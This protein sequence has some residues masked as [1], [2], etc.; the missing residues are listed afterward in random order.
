MGLVVYE[1]LRFDGKSSLDYDVRISGSGTYAAPARDVQSVS[2]PGRNG[3]L[4]IDNGRFSNVKIKYPAYITKN[5]RENFDAFK[6][7]MLSRIGYK[8]LEDSYHPEYYRMAC[9]SQAVE[10]KMST[11]NRAGSFDLVFDCDPRRFLKSGTR[12]KVYSGAGIVFNLKNPT[13]FQAKPLIRAYGTGTIDINGRTITITQANEYTD[14][15]SE[16]ENA[17][18]GSTNCNAN[19]TFGNSWHLFPVLVPGLNVISF[20][21]LTSIEVTPNWWTI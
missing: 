12:A 1:Y 16:S 8:K 9:Y 21:G 5:F 17:Y 19:I 13:E 4:H 20:T 7:F 2:V 6:A 3:D 15:N 14:I 11:L 18:K 10:P